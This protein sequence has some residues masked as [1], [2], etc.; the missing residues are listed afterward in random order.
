MF[1][2]L[3]CGCSKKHKLTR[4]VDAHFWRGHVVAIAF[5]IA[6]YVLDRDAGARQQFGQVAVE[7]EQIQAEPLADELVT[8]VQRPRVDLAKKSVRVLAVFTD[9]R[10]R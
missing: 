7:F 6:R 2:A 3:D 10:G 1:G 4:C 9:D 8:A 5:L